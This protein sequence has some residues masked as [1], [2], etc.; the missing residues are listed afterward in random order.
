[1]KA[2]TRK[3]LWVR[4]KLIVRD[5]VDIE[6]CR[7]VTLRNLLQPVTVP[8]DLSLILAPHKIGNAWRARNVRNIRH[9]DSSSRLLFERAE[10]L[11]VV[12]RKLFEC[13]TMTD[14]IDADADCHQVRIQRDTS[15]QLIA[16]H[17]SS[18]G[19]THAKI[20]QS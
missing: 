13:E 1:M 17:V 19:A 15:L 3:I 6:D 16:Q 8:R 5:R 11:F 7:A 12:F 4:R 10:N 14:V 20:S 2:V 9:H 18:C